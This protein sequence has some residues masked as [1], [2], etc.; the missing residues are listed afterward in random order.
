MRVLIFLLCC[1]SALAFA[2]ANN[3]SCSSL[4]D[5]GWLE[6]NWLEQKEN[7]VSAEL[8]KTVSP[9]TMEGS[10]R[11]LKNGKL[12]HYE[13]IRL[14][15]MSGQVFYMV[16]VDKN[17]FPIPFKL[18]VCSNKQYFF[19]NLQHDFPRRIDYTQLDDSSMR[20]DVTD[21]QDRGFSINYSRK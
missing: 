14:V 15:E 21:G 16:K 12:M 19:Q 10:A 18:V 1:H 17:P 7:K 13:T 3:D 6:G 9:G 20:V 8:W 4:Q 2:G 11:V 5:L